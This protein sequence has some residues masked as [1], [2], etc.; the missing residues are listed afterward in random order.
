MN[1]LDSYYRA[2]LAYRAVTEQNRDCNNFRN[3][4]AKAGTENEKIVITRA[5]CTIDEEWINEIELGLEFIEKAIKEERQFIYSNGE[6]LPVEKVKH[7]STETV[8]HLAKHS[9]LIGKT[10][11]T[12]DFIPDK[13]YTVE[14][15]NDYAVY[16]NR[17]LYMLLSYLRDFVSL[18]YSKILELCNKYDGVLKIEKEA[19]LPKQK[20]TLSIYLHDERSDDP[21]LREQNG[22]KEIID[23]IDVIL[24]AIIS[25]LAT[26]LMEVAAKTP[27]LKPPITKTNILKMDN[28]FKGAV[29]LYDY[30]IS[31]TG[32][33]YET[34]EFK[35]EISPFRGETASEFSDVAANLAF[36]TYE[37]G[38][39]I[40]TVLKNSYDKEERKRKDEAI[41]R[42]EEKLIATKKKLALAEIPA[43]EYVYELENQIKALESRNAEVDA[44]RKE[45]YKLRDRN[46]ELI[47]KAVLSDEK[48]EKISRDSEASKDSYEKAIEDI[49]ADCNTRIR[50]STIKSDTELKALHDEYHAKINAAHDE[51]QKVRED[52]EK[53]LDNMKKLIEKSEKA[54]AEFD[55]Q[56][57]KLTEE[58]LCCEARI[59]ALK[60]QQNLMTDEDDFTEREAF[61]ELEA[62]F[63]AFKKFYKI[64]WGKAKKKI[65]SK[66]LTSDNIKGK[67]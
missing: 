38:L 7:V 39:G 8:K 52:F 18:R 6:V 45:L 57:K 42:R 24:K 17:F 30:I 35:T 48:A 55:E 15:L 51:A 54:L 5:I 28:N 14:R 40:E 13:L 31:Y 16:E 61:A 23:R 1:Q 59:K 62:E 34:D 19:V 20:L 29:A 2:L 9:N 12:D 22:L 43:E 4:L 3:Q 60:M 56:N 65:R 37:H 63:N 64:Q 49:K 50:E 36:L 33:G 41:R 44:I 32:P 47:Y 66:I 46:E 58:K 27:L 67:K 25:F 21:F 10:D 26:P 53:E 11:N